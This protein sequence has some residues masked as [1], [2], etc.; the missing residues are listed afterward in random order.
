MAKLVAKASRP[1]SAPK[2]VRHVVRWNVNI[3]SIIMALVVA[4]L[5]LTGTDSVSP[6]FSGLL[7]FL[8]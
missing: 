7:K 3:A 6:V 2:R 8:R 4:Y 5:A 1:H